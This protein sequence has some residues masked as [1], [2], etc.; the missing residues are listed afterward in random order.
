[1][2]YDKQVAQLV[3]LIAVINT[4][5]TKNER[6]KLITLCTIDVHSRDVV[7]RLMDERVESASCFQ[8]QSQLRY[9]QNEKTKECQVPLLTRLL[10]MLHP[11]QHSTLVMRPRALQGTP[12]ITASGVQSDRP[13]LMC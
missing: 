3:D 12:P 11:V 2:E 5:L 4:N 9:Y 6:K 10:L 1:M 8:W 7:S 13:M